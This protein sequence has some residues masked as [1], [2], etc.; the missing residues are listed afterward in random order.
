MK[1]IAIPSKVRIG[2][3]DYKVAFKDIIHMDG[4]TTWS[5][6]ISYN[7]TFIEIL[8]SINHQRQCET[9]FHEVVHGILDEF[10]IKDHDE[11]L[12][13]S[14]AKG[15]YQLMRDNYFYAEVGE[16]DGQITS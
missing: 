14:M 8:N 13:D 5:G 7:D 4:K 10:G 15:L 16:N 11:Y 12:V 1:V 9:F 6:K 3:V 2:G